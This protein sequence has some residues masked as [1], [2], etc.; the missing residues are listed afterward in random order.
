MKALERLTN[1][2]DLR[3]PNVEM[4]VATIRA[5]LSEQTV[6]KA[7]DD[8]RDRLTYQLDQWAATDEHRVAY[9]ALRALASTLEQ[10]PS[11]QQ[12]R[13]RE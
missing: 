3:I 10:P 2:L 6:E 11:L 1:D 8:F 13:E 7:R 9:Q 4:D 12:P 5:A